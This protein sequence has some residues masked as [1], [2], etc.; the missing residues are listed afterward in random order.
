M[1]NMQYF[2]QFSFIKFF[3]FHFIFSMIYGKTYLDSTLGIMEPRLSRRGRKQ[4]KSFSSSF[5]AKKSI[6]HT[7]SSVYRCLENYISKREKLTN[8][9][10]YLKIS[11]PL[12]DLQK[13]NSAK[14]SLTKK[15][16]FAGAALS[17]STSNNL[18]HLFCSSPTS[19]GVTKII[20]QAMPVSIFFQGV[21]T[22]ILRKKSSEKSKFF[23]HRKIITNGSNIC[24]SFPNDTRSSKT[25][26]SCFHHIVEAVRYV[27]KNVKKTEASNTY[28][29]LLS[30]ICFLI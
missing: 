2:A 12:L 17:L 11:P 23:C 19:F 5:G 28:L 24:S 10:P 16:S 8:Y 25:I 6:K 22:K 18:S 26:D 21:R 1:H 7:L 27:D 20:C 15:Y 9:T 3:F 13:D 14:V 30:S 29:C 4:I